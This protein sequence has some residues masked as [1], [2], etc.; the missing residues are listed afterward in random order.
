MVYRIAQNIRQ[1][2]D[3]NEILNTTVT[4]VQKIL[5]T[6]RVIICRFHPDGSSVVVTESVKTGLQPIRPL[7]IPDSYF[8]CLQTQGHVYQQQMVRVIPDLSSAGF[9]DGD[10]DF[11]AKLQVKST[12]I[13]PILDGD[14]LWGLLVAHNCSIL[15]V[16][17]SWESELLKQLA[18][19]LAIAIQQSELYQKLQLA[20][21]QLENMAMVD[22]LT[23][24]ANRRCFDDKFKSIWEHLL[25]EQGCLS[26]LLCDID[27]FKQY[28]DT[29]G[30][31]AGDICLTLIAQAMR[32]VVNRATDLVARYG[33]EEFVIILPYTSS[34]GAIQIAQNIHEAIQQ[35]NIPHVASKVQQ[36]VT[37]STGIATV[38][39]DTN[40]SP[41][42]LIE[43]ADKA[44]YQAK[45]EG[46]NRYL[47][48]QLYQYK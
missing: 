35:M 19:Q 18:I 1:S 11:L 44:L 10:R 14:H 46:R 9:T 7:S 6:D 43:A 37:L 47:L 24:I 34:Y 23:Q 26:L 30:H 4:E 20:N 32:Q 33:G 36:Y 2:L 12:I 27:F 41:C 16:W 5:H 39:P 45:A 13:V 38:I 22:Q 29:Y 21:Q 42:D 3:L 31:G 48:N 25:R 17:Q 40:L 28:N 8:K 15:R